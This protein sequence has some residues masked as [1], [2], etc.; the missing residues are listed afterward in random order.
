MSEPEYPAPTALDVADALIACLRDPAA[1]PTALAH[2]L[3][4]QMPAEAALLVAAEMLG[5]EVAHMLPDGIALHR[6]VLA[7]R[8]AVFGARHPAVAA[9]LQRLAEGHVLMDEFAAAEALLRQASSICRDWPGQAGLTAIL[10]DLGRVL[11]RRAGADAQAVLQE[12]WRRQCDEGAHPLDRLATRKALRDL[13]IVSGDP[14]VWEHSLAVI[15]LAEQAHGVVS[16][17]V[18]IARLEAALAAPCPED[19][20]PLQ[21]DVHGAAAILRHPS[22]AGQPGVWF[23]FRLLSR[24]HAQVGWREPS[25]QALLAAQAALDAE[26]DAGPLARLEMHLAFA[27]WALHFAAAIVARPLLDAAYDALQAM[28]GPPGARIAEMLMRR[29]D[30]FQRL[31]Q[32]PQA[33]VDLIAALTLRRSSLGDR[34][35]VIAETHLALGD[36]A[37]HSG[38]Y[39]ASQAHYDEGLALHAGSARVYAALLGGQARLASDLGDQEQAVQLQSQAGEALLALLGPAHPT[40]LAAEATLAAILMRAGDPDGAERMI[41]AALARQ[42]AATRTPLGRPH[43]DLASTLCDAGAL[44]A[45]RGDHSGS[46][47]HFATA[48]DLLDRLFGRAHPD[49]ATARLGQAAAALAL[50]QPEIARDLAADGL[51]RG[52]AQIPAEAQWR[53]YALLADAVA[54][55]GQHALAIGLGKLAVNLLQSARTALAPLSQSLQ[56][57]LL[58]FRHDTY[59]MVTDRLIAADRLPE[60]QQIVAMLKAAELREGLRGPPRPGLATLSPREAGW[61]AAMVHLVGDVH[62]LHDAEADIGDGIP[63]LPEHQAALA[64][65]AGPRQAAEQAW[66]AWVAAASAMSAAPQQGEAPD[67]AGLTRLQGWLAASRPAA[68]ALDYLLLSDRLEI[69]VTTGT[70]QRVVRVASDALTLRRDAFAFWL[71]LRDRTPAAD[72]LA[73]S[74]HET[75]FAPVA[76]DVVASGAVIIVLQLTGALRYVP[77]AA[78]HDGHL[79]LAARYGFVLRATGAPA[80]ARSHNTG[81]AALFAATLATAEAPGLPYAAQEIDAIGVVLADATRD[82]D[83]AFTTATLRQRLAGGPAIVHLASHFQFVPA[84]EPRSALLLGDGTRLCAAELLDGSFQ[85][86]GIELLTLSACETGL[87]SGDGDAEAGREIEGLPAALL[88]AGVHTVLAALWPADDASTG[89]LMAR[90]YRAWRQQNL[91]APLALRE[92]QLAIGDQAAPA[93]QRRLTVPDERPAPPA[94]PQ[95]CHPYLWAGFVL[96]TTDEALA[97]AAGQ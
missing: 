90:F 94:E 80:A 74:L 89:A 63:A 27:D 82:R 78:L 85:L 61:H 54:A 67:P 36:L 75:L 52:T 13:S 45:I 2:M 19:V 5:S 81:P 51:A 93:V 49:L 50:G 31:G 26:P 23:G 25:R 41:Q 37:L 71:A 86:E 30:M 95:P 32:L 14:E 91:P 28:A 84:Q 40:T 56:A 33:Q 24:W 97:A 60:A 43:A 39:T 76:A 47:T 21:Q 9:T 57:Q 35:P 16:P 69:I 22:C 38:D 17:Q 72:A 15:A 6:C 44:A 20:E 34:H 42:H 7:L 77:W 10:A 65:L 88:A 53:L 8:Q 62:R 58:G 70:S 66:R 83:A 12:A 29:A 4:A 48:A 96:F 18:A 73:R 1:D 55:R 11:A 3:L 92:A 59:K 64:A 68:V 79:P 87:A 46:A